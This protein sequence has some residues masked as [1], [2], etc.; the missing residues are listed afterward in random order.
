ML[1]PVAVAALFASVA[2]ACSSDD[3]AG[4]K[5]L[6]DDVAATGPD[7]CRLLEPSEIDRATG[8]AVDDG[9]VSTSSASG[10]DGPEVCH[11]EDGHRQGVV[12]VAVDDADGAGAFAAARDAALAEHGSEVTDADVP[13][14]S[15]AFQVPASGQVAMVVDGRF[16]E[17]STVGIGVGDQAHLQLAQLAAGRA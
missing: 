7:P 11:F 15:E 9:T 1:I 3:D 14:A 12:Q 13:G 10:P 16:V 2:V 17:V 5:G 8:W 6:G 4:P